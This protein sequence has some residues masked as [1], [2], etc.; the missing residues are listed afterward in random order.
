MWVLVGVAEDA[1]HGNIGAAD[2]LGNVAIEVFSGDDIDGIGPRD[3]DRREH[4]EKCPQEDMTPGR[5]YS[6]PARQP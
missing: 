2:L 1:G 4:A 6:N 3:G 5:I